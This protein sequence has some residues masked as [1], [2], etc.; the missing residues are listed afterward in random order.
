[1]VRIKCKGKKN[2][3]ILMSSVLQVRKIISHGTVMFLNEMKPTD[4][5]VG[6]TDVLGV[7]VEFLIIFF[8]FRN[9]IY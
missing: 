8:Y 2:V 6:R 1:M 3:R 7:R 4:F 9:N 5:T